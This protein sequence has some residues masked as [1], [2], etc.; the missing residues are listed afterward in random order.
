LTSLIFE[1]AENVVVG[2]DQALSQLRIEWSLLPRLNLA[3]YSSSFSSHDSRFFASWNDQGREKV[4]AGQIAIAW[5]SL[6]VR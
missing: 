3:T 5:K 2:S 1:L 4:Q 6:S